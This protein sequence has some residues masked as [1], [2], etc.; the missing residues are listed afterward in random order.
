[1]NSL[2]FA[3]S[4]LYVKSTGRTMSTP[5][6]R[7]DLV[8]LTPETNLLV[9]L[10]AKIFIWELQLQTRFSLKVEIVSIVTSTQPTSN[11]RGTTATPN[12]YNR[13]I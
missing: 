7:C 6:A 5:R 4:G 8:N 9:S 2:S 1:M 11:Q 3:V 12:D 13:I 10:L